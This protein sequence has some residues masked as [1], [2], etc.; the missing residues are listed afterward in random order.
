[1]LTWQRAHA[2]ATSSW[3]DAATSCQGLTLG[4][5]AGWRLPTARELQTLVDVRAG[6]PSIDTAAFPN[7]TAGAFFSAAPYSSNPAKPWIVSFSAGRTVDDSAAASDLVR[8][9]R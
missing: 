7:T 4:G 9:V 2:T 8:C 6:N 3:A 5:L 1:M